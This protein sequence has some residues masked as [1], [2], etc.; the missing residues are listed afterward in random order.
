MQVETVTQKMKGKHEDLLDY[1]AMAFKEQLLTNFK[2]PEMMKFNGNGDHKAYLH[3]YV[4]LM[5]ATGLSQNQVQKIFGMLGN[6]VRIR[7]SPQA[8]V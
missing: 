6:R 8:P 2:M 4:S 3:Q 1:N 5:S 7:S